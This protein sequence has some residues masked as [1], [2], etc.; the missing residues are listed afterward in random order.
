MWIVDFSENVWHF[1]VRLVISV[2]CGIL[3]GFERKN[4]SK[5]A[6]IRTH[7]IVCMA[8]A[9][10]MIV[11]RYLTSADFG[12]EGTTGDP[13]RIGAQI[14][15]GIGFLGAGIIM[16][17]RDAMR[18]ITTAA[19][20]WATSAIGMAIGAGFVITG[21][22]ATLIIL[23]LQFV[24]HLPI[25]AFQTRH[26]ATVK[27]KVWMETDDVVDRI[28]TDFTSPKVSSYAAKIE[29]GKIIATVYIVTSGVCS[30]KEIDQIIKKYPSHILAIEQV[31]EV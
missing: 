13:A 3:I 14:V 24:F 28:M 18:G 6:G 17:R 1:V 5:E 4:R 7:A 10:F 11:S 31:E 30:V 19:G 26:L 16:Y 20:I 25:K 23:V 22:T 2:V 29:D 21:I 12:G 8:A 27:L 15:T 9:L